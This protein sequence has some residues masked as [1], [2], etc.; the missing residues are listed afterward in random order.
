MRHYLYQWYILVAI[1]MTA[2]MVIGGTRMGFGLWYLFSPHRE[3]DYLVN[4]LKPH[5]D[6][7]SLWVV[8]SGIA[9]FAFFPRTFRILFNGF[10]PLIAV[11][12]IVLGFRIIALTLRPKLKSQLSLSLWDVCIALGNTIPLF[13]LGLTAGY[14]LKGVPLYTA[15]QYNV[16]VLGYLN[17]FTVVVGLLTVFAATSLSYSAIAWNSDGIIRFFARKWAFYSSLIMCVL[18]FDLSLWSLLLSPYISSSLRSN[19]L[20]LIVPGITFFASAMLPFLLWKRRFKLA[21]AAAVVV[22]AGLVVTFFLT[23]YPHLRVIFSRANPVRDFMPRGRYGGRQGRRAVYSALVAERKRYFPT[24]I[25]LM[26][27]TVLL[28]IKMFLLH[29]K[30]VHCPLPFDKEDEDLL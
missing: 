26:L 19:Q 11:I 2:Y 28:Q 15:G 13:L 24:Y 10:Y 7:S 23:I 18:I 16:N 8:M 14:I 1:M 6:G 21:Y 30:R 20:L 5:V 4:S 25:F 3:R 27:G 22:M 29:H 12:F 9:L 17:H